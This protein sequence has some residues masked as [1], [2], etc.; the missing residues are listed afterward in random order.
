MSQHTGPY[1]PQDEGSTAEPSTVEVAR[2]EAG[3][4]GQ[5]AR[6]A[7]G[8]VA[9]TATDQAK[10]V[11]A[12]TGRQARDL[13]GEAQ[14]QAR[15]QASIQQQK[16]AQQLR[17]VADEL[18]EMVAKGGQSGLATE[19]ARQTADRMDKTASWLEQR[20]PGDLLEGVRDFA[21]RRPGTFLV[22]AAIAGLAAGRLTRGLTG[23]ADSAPGPQ[24]SAVSGVPAENALEPA[25]GDGTGYTAVPADMA[26]SEPASPAYPAEPV[27]R[28][29][30]TYPAEPS[31]TGYQP[32]PA[33]PAETAYPAEPDPAQRY[34]GPGQP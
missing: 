13:L 24:S 20:Q 8:Q 32:E 19:V 16:T 1:V 15:D 10:N 21:R 18:H 7:G 22:G 23:G 29:D 28:P 3:N 11:V 14:G 2:A 9:Q 25:V 34:I 30:E 26:V 5:H 27:Y 17:T 33:Y 4:V 31:Q 6:E 12:E